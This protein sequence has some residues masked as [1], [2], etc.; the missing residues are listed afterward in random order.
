MITDIHRRK[1]PEGRSKVNTTMSLESTKY[2]QAVELSRFDPKILLMALIKAAEKKGDTDLLFVY[3]S[4]YKNRNGDVPKLRKL[5]EQAAGKP[6]KLRPVQ[7]LAY[8]LD[9]RL[10]KT[11]LVVKS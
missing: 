7:G 11:R 2:R 8:L 4:I 6:V 10:S 9:N 1:E 3:K 5:L